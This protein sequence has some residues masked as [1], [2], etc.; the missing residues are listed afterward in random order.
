MNYRK[1][2]LLTVMLKVDLVNQDN[3]GHLAK[4]FVETLCISDVEV[5]N[6]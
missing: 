4:V 2:C 3:K 1:L 6:I 5:V